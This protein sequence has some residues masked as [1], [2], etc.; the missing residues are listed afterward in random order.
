V[1]HGDQVD[2]VGGGCG[3]TSRPAPGAGSSTGVGSATGS[4]GAGASQ[5][6]PGPGTRRPVPRSAPGPVRSGGTTASSSSA[7]AGAGMAGRG[8]DVG[9][10]SSSGA[11]AATGGARPPRPRGH[12]GEQVRRDAS[13]QR[14][15]DADRDG[16][17]DRAV[18]RPARSPSVRAVQGCRVIMTVPFVTEGA[19]IP[20]D[21]RHLPEV[22]STRGGPPR[23]SDVPA[24]TRGVGRPRAAHHPRVGPT[25]ARIRGL[26]GRRAR[27]GGR[28]R[29]SCGPARQPFG[30]PGKN[31]LVRATYSS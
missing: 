4:C 9:I 20:P 13:G 12:A 1:L 3:S 28:D 21:A 5:V 7:S 16:G 10:V 27:A 6:P 15:H 31:A 8:G 24:D 2:R 11:G 14:E 19:F 17:G 26:S 18:A 23:P 30:G 25:C 22:A 29:R